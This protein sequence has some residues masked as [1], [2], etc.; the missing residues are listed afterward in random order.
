M[1]RK[2]HLNT[3]PVGIAT[4]D[5]VLRARFQGTP[6]HVINYLFFVA[7]ELR[8]IMASLG[9]RT[10]DEMVGRVDRITVRADASIRRPARSTSAT[11]S[12]R[13]RRRPQHERAPADD[14]VLAVTADQT[15]VEGAA[16][17]H[18][19]RRA[20]RRCRST[21]TNADRAV[22]REARRRDRAEARRRRAAGRHRGR[23]GHGTAGQSFGA[24]A[25]RGMLIVARGRRERLRRQGA[26]R[27]RAR[28]PAAG[29]RR[30]PQPGR[31]RHRRQHVSSTARPRAASS[32]PV[33]AGERFAVRNSGAAAVVEGVGDSRLRVHD[34]R[35]G[36]R[37]RARRVETSAP[38]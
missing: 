32:S 1:M 21:L 12:A 3:C 37:A 31:E 24:F 11:C 19:V 10:L 27:R 29:A 23:R 33:S 16:P 34:R 9:F 22:R 6:E 7:E 36:G 35:G 4:Q 25:A 30:L 20:H 13:S 28:G 26:L 5:P 2:C 38:G 15:L 8:A 17:E 18:Q 14:G